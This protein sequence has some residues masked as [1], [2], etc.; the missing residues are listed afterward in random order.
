MSTNRFKRKGK[1]KYLHLEGYLLKGA[2]WRSL[3]PN[4][5]VAYLELR[6]RYNGI[7]NG[8][9][10]LSCRELAEVLQSSKDTAL[11]ALNDL[12]GRG[13]TR[14][15][16]AS[17]FGRKDR[18]STEWRLTE[19]GCDVTGSLPSKEFTRWGLAEI[20][21]A[22]LGDTQAHHRDR[23]CQIAPEKAAH[24]RTTGTVNDVL[25]NPQAHHRDTYNITTGGRS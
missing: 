5:K 14:K 21:Q 6:W 2:A 16:K 10:G 12:V 19:F 24:S 11:R 13:F 23:A 9:I 7:N 15:M 3:T 17:H 18:T 4:A 22:H 8:R 20:S 1:A 25:A